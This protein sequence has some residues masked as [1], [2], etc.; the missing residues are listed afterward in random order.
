MPADSLIAHLVEN[1]SWR[2]QIVRI[3]G[4]VKYGGGDFFEILKT[5]SQIKPADKEEWYKSWND[6]AHRKREQ[7]KSELEQA[8]VYTASSL[9]LKASNYYRMADFYLSLDDPRE[10]PTYDKIVNCFKNAWV[11]FDHPIQE[12]NIKF[13]GES[14]PAYFLKSGKE[15]K[16]AP[17]V[18]LMGGADSV[19]EEK[20]F[21]GA[22]SCIKRKMN[23]LLVDGP[24]QGFPLRHLKRYLIHDYEKFVSA[25]VDELEKREDVDSKKI[26]YV[27]TSLGGYF[28]G[29]AAAFEERLA[30]VVMWGACYDVLSDIYN[31]FPP[32]RERIRAILGV[33]NDDEVKEK[34]REFNL[35]GLVEK[36]RCPLLII[37]GEDD[38]ICSPTAV[39]KVFSQAKCEKKLV[40]YK[41]DELGSLH[42][43]HDN[44]DEVSSLV[45]DWLADTFKNSI[46]N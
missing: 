30:A 45:F 39:Q 26:A 46:P 3:I 41:K 6:L 23:C 44:A 8:H 40:M 15:T 20:Y 37:H 27:G 35:S 9:F 13:Q 14:F 2:H 22:L 17:T 34:L 10:L 25:V 4:Q 16:R 28:A 43:Q 19:K 42:S 18:I 21:G 11:G 33:K 7:A 24:G 5:V 29:R 12:I 38:Y 36:I 31:Y 1:S 32:I